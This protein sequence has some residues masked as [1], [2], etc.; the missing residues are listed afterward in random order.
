[1]LIKQC[2][3]FWLNSHLKADIVASYFSTTNHSSLTSYITM[4]DWLITDFEP[5][6]HVYTVSELNAEVAQLFNQTFPVIT[7]E[8]ELSGLSQPGSGHWYFTI[9]DL[10]S[11]IRAAMFKR[12]NSRVRFQ[13]KHGDLVTVQARVTLYQQRGQYQL[14]VQS[15][16][17]A[18]DGKLQQ[19]VERLKQRLQAEGLFDSERKQALPA[20]IQRTGVI[21]SAS[22]AALQDVLSVLQRR[23]PLME[24]IVYPASVQGDL[25]TGQIIEQLQTAQLRNEV[26][27]LLLVRGGGSLEDLHA[28][29]DEGVVRAVADCRLPIVCGVGHEIDFSLADFAADQRAPTPSAAAE[30]I[31][32]DQQNVT[33]RLQAAKQFLQRHLRQQLAIA[34][35]ELAY[36]QRRFNQVHI[37]RRLQVL[38]Q[39]LDD[40]RGD[41]QQSL[42]YQMNRHNN[43]IKLLQQRLQSVHPRHQIQRQ[44]DQINAIS[45]RLH[46]PMT[47][48]F[49][50][51]RT[52]LTRLKQ[53]LQQAVQRYLDQQMRLLANRRQY[54]FS[55]SPARRLPIQQRQLQQTADRLHRLPVQMIQTYRQRLQQY[56]RSL[57]AISPNKT[58]E[59]GYAIVSQPET[60][61]TI[62]SVMQTT[63]DQ[64]L[65]VRLKDGKLGVK[66]TKKWQ[67]PL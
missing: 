62:T 47:Q 23:A 52:Q 57:V 18:G 8:G 2:A 10:S 19:A 32:T 40:A 34:H 43:A 29:N 44:A 17:L 63:A 9:K 65:T 60:D 51:Y 67:N 27:V 16:E 61:A 35:R 31:S 3:K 66:V 1:M 6:T 7:L 58:L 50:A 59:R 37:D 46:R 36:L 5:E 26:D 64:A 4:S 11:E 42:R 30:L 22:G 14:V 53:Q 12:D 38:A 45:Q 15:M 13:P 55:Q 48:Q 25:A 20:T 41:L 56:R 28:F 39:R 24:V 21:T 49:E 33:E 54:L